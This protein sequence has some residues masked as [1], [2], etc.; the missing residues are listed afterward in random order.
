MKKKKSLK[1]N[2]VEIIIDKTNTIRKGIVR[3][4]KVFVFKR[5][6][7]QFEDQL[8]L[9]RAHSAAPSLVLNHFEHTQ[10]CYNIYK[11]YNV[12]NYKIDTLSTK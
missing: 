7:S 5:F 9:S 2:S 1:T 3:R 10:Q 12:Y 4:N 8:K 11:V 6:Q